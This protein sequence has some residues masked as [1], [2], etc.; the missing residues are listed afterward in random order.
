MNFSALFAKYIEYV[1]SEAHW[2]PLAESIVLI[3]E[4]TNYQYQIYE[5][6]SVAKKIK[7]NQPS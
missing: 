1:Q 7:L 4:L 5:S 2:M 3:S 6:L